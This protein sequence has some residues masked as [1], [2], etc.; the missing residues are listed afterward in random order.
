MAKKVST[1]GILV[2]LALIFA[3]VERFFILPISVPGIKLGF[4]NI[5]TLLALYLVPWQGALLISVGRVLLSTLLF[6]SPG[7]LLFSLGGCLLSFFVMLGAKRSGLF[8][9]TGLGVCGG[10]FH[11]IGQI[12]VAACVIQNIYLLG[13]LPILMVAGSICGFITGKI[14]FYVLRQL[15]H[16]HILPPEEKN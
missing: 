13:Y 4:A 5:V 11:N 14:S 2:C 1:Y 10:V 12:A 3:Y 15:R 6:S 16:S 9:V 7:S 8:S